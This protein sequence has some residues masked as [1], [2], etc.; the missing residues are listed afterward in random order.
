MFP[1]KFDFFYMINVVNPKNLFRD[2]KRSQ[3]FGTRKL[4]KTAKLE[5]CQNEPDGIGGRPPTSIWIKIPL[6]IV[7]LVTCLGRL[8]FLEANTLILIIL[9]SQLVL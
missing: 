9:V 2:S 8:V 3:K 4:E 6:F 5:N 1:L 7:V